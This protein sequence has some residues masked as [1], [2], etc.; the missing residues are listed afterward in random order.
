MQL[1]RF[2]PQDEQSMHSHAILTIYVYYLYMCVEKKLV[3]WELEKRLQR[4]HGVVQSSMR[5]ASTSV[6]RQYDVMCLLGYMLGLIK[7][8]VI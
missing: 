3:S 7:L 2:Q 1:S 8:T 5:R 4:K 6:G